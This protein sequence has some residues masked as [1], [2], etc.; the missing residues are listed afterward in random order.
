MIFL[1]R[2]RL[3]CLLALFVSGEGRAV[4]AQTPTHPLAPE[5]STPLGAPI[6]R[7]L[8]P[9][10]GEVVHGVAIIRFQTQ[11][12]IITSLFLPPAQ[13][14]AALPAAHLHVSVDGAEWHWVH[15]TAD[16]VVIAPLSPGEHTV[17]LELAGSDHRPL[18]TRTVRFTV[19]AR[20]IPAAD[21]AAHASM[22][23]SA[24]QARWELRLPSGALVS[25][26]AQ[27]DNIKD[28]ALSAVQLSYVVRPR[29]ALTATLGWARSRDLA[30]ADDPKLDVF[31]Y[32][33]GAEVRAPRWVAGELLT[34]TPFLGAG[35]GG[36]SYN[37]R[38]LDLDATHNVA[39]YATV[40]G[41]AGVGRLRLRL[42][43]RDYVAGFKPLGGNGVSSTHNDVV[44]MFG[45]SFV[46]SPA[47]RAR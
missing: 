42:E 38:A 20:P 2:A 33:V 16:P 36:R 17:S 35:V 37:Y 43:V 29:I 18:D 34:L 5:H 23:Q 1:P 13:Q 3:L 24:V 32:D 26:G 7:I 9:T 11:N 8:S 22:A 47:Q 12:V 41:E 45:L 25:T 28:A 14:R 44:A 19:V 21:H 27:R 39:A 46:K 10:S 15:S 4:H 6:L 40:G 31:S 30:S